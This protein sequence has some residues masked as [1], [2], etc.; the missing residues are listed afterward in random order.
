M[1]GEVKDLMQGSTI[2]KLIQDK[3]LPI[4]DVNY[5]FCTRYRSD[6]IVFVHQAAKR[7]EMSNQT[8]PQLTMYQRQYLMRICYENGS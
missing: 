7:N 5:R 6:V 8:K 3:N 1:R 2:K 4:M